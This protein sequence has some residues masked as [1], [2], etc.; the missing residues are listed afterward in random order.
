AKIYE[1]T[2]RKDFRR[3]GADNGG[4]IKV[5]NESIKL[6]EKSLDEAVILDKA[7]QIKQKNVFTAQEVFSKVDS[8]YW[9]V[10]SKDKKL[11]NLISGLT[12]AE[13]WD[14]LI[15]GKVNGILIK[16]KQSITERI[17]KNRK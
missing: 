4:R 6:T 5:E 7:W 2:L 8:F 12:E 17:N 15:D 13:L 1:A 3:E 16:K 14:T 9:S 11:N 10:Q